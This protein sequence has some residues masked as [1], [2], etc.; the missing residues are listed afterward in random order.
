LQSTAILLLV[1]CASPPAPPPPTAT[2]PVGSPYQIKA[3][4]YLDI[5]FYKTP[6]LNLEVPVRPDGNISL[7]LI[8]DVQAAGLQPGELA[9]TLRERYA[10]ELENPR[11]SVIV[12]AFGGQVYV[13]GEVKTPSA[14]PFAMGITALQ[15]ISLAGGFLDTAQPNSVILMRFEDGQYR[16][17]RLPLKDTRSGKGLGQDVRLIAAPN[18]PQPQR[19]SANVHR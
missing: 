3:G 19:N 5:R 14:A 15:A 13:E 12:R 1:G 6:E 11:V 8:G 18:L 9:A 16:G 7:E 10:S 17:Y 4:D 2:Q